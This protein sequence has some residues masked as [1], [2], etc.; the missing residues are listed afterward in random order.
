VKT[1]IRTAFAILLV[2]ILGTTSVSQD[3]RWR[4]KLSDQRVVDSLALV[5]VDRD[6]LYATRNVAQHSFHLPDIAELRYVRES[7]ITSYILFGAF[8]GIPIGQIALATDASARNRDVGVLPYFGEGILIGGAAGGLMGWISGQDDV[9]PLGQE[10]RMAKALLLSSLIDDEKQKKA[11]ERLEDSAFA[12]RQQHPRRYWITVDRGRGELGHASFGWKTQ[13][14]WRAA[15]G[16]ELAPAFS[17]CLHLDYSL[18][19]ISSDEMGSWLSPATA[20]RYNLACY[21]GCVFLRIVEVG[22]G[23]V[24]SQ[25]DRVFSNSLYQPSAQWGQT[26]SATVHVLFVVGFGYQLQFFDH[27]M[28]PFGLCLRSSTFEDANGSS[29]VLRIGLGYKF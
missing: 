28:I 23:A 20:K 19:N 7:T 3:H 6:S 22:A 15:L 29:A 9:Y 10:S 4:V 1:T 11:D 14:S 2:L 24:Y 8:A 5:S 12:Y 27:V 13:Y 18:D 16:M 25:S 26:G 17:W 21:A